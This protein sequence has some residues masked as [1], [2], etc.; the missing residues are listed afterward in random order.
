[1]RRDERVYRRL[2][3]IFEEALTKKFNRVSDK[4]SLFVRIQD[5]IGYKSGMND[6]LFR[7]GE[8]P[9]H[10]G[11]ALIGL[12]VLALILLLAIAIVVARCTRG[13]LEAVPG[14]AGR[15]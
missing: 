2:T 13:G 5:R 10:T 3:M 12:G 6:I 15:P 8:W 9:V 14:A 4:F 1:M 7:V 11:D